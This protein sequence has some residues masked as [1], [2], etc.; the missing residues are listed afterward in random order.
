[1]KRINVELI[2]KK[3]AAANDGLLTPE[4]VVEFARP[5]TSPLHKR[6]TWDNTEAAYKY[7]LWEARQLI[8]VTVKMVDIGGKKKP[9]RVFV[10]LTPD[11]E[12]GGY[13]EINTV[14]SGGDY[15]RQLILD[16]LAE[17]AVFEMK[18]AELKE[19]SDLFR[20][21]KELREQLGT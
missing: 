6:F 21:S 16:A 9:V 13:R 11:R 20:K 17:L 10:S 14:L 18:Y 5:A 15:R 19:L 7:R 1:M 12:D 8:S 4:A 3:I 2:L